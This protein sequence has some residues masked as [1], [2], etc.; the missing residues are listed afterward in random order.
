MSGQFPVRRRLCAC[1][2]LLFAACS[3]AKDPEQEREARARRGAHGDIVIA[4]AWPW[5]LRKEI[6]YGE[7]LEM[8]VA[9]VNAGGG[10]IGR[11]LRVVRYD[12]HESRPRR[13]PRIRT[14][15]PWSG[16]CNRT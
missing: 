2:L 13:S 15:W 7:G 12:D 5:E 6:R 9:E 10:V 1:A 16:T 14:S 4:A 8:A 3:T 11:R